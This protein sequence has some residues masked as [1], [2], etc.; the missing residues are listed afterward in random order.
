[1]A[2]KAFSLSREPTLVPSYHVYGDMIDTNIIPA[3]LFSSSLLTENAEPRSGSST[4]V[5]LTFEVHVAARRYCR[6]YYRRDSIAG[7][8]AASSQYLHSYLQSASV[9]AF[10]LHSSQTCT[11][12]CFYYLING[13]LGRR[14]LF[15]NF[16]LL[17]SSSTNSCLSK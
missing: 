8:A 10:C 7:A 1:M 12:R 14:Y 15:L 2:T 4:A 16:L 13:L 6:L 3:Y 5:S 9:D 17:E 11:L